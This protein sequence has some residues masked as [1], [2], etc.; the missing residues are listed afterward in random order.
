VRDPQSNG[1]VI[2]IV[3]NLDD[4]LRRVRVRFPHLNDEQSYWARL[5]TPMAGPGRGIYFRPEPND[6]VLV[7]MEQGDPRRAYV[8]GSL[9]SQAD[10]PPADDGNA[11][12]NNWRLIMS[13]SG[14]L[15]KWDDTKGKERIEIVACGGKQRIVLDSAN[16]KIEVTCDTGDVEISAPAGSVKVDA[17]SVNLTASEDMRLQAGTTLTISGT[18]VNIN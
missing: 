17:R 10:L 12:E 3:C 18:T 6:E 11:K 7:A 16:Q 14:N 15:I 2:G 4:T 13:R 9:W 1:I 8:L 5:V